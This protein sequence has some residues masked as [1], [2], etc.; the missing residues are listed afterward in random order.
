MTSI[1]LL[2]MRCEMFSINRHLVPLKLPLNNPAAINNRAIKLSNRL[3]ILW[4]VSRMA[5]FEHRSVNRRIRRSLFTK[6][7]LTKSSKSDGI[8]T[9]LKRK[10]WCHSINYGVQ[11][12]EK[13]NCVK[14][15]STDVSLIE[16]LY[17]RRSGFPSEFPVL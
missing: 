17:R 14:R 7:I 3:T 8:R 15:F 4:I 6:M 13:S 11:S 10:R 5:V 9:E 12:F 1:R 2:L 16:S